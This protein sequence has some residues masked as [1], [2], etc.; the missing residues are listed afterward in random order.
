MTDAKFHRAIYKDPKVKVVWQSKNKR[1]RITKHKWG[2]M[3]Y[4]VTY[5]ETRVTGEDPIASLCWNRIRANCSYFNIRKFL[6]LLNGKTFHVK[7]FRRLNKKGSW[8]LWIFVGALEADIKG[9]HRKWGVKLQHWGKTK[10]TIHGRTRS[11]KSN[12]YSFE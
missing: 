9:Y 12:R 7:G 2:L 8:G 11:Y 3:F 5:Y 6:H 4:H 10:F 1:F